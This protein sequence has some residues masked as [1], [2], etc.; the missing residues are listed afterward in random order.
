MEN[1]KRNL[2]KTVPY[3]LQIIPGQSLKRQDKPW[4]T[5]EILLG[6]LLMGISDD[7]VSPLGPL[8]DSLICVSDNDALFRMCR[9]GIAGN[10]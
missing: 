1:L 7:G 6:I 10:C 9:K 8:T 3:F 2:M 5:Q 4:C